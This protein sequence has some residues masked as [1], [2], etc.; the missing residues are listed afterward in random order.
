M[1]TAQAAHRDHPPRT[2][3]FPVRSRGHRITPTQ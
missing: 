2:L 3:P 1:P